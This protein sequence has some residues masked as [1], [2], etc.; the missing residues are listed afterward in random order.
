MT[1]PLITRHGEVRMSQRGIRETDLNLGLD[2]G[3]ELGTDRVMLTTKD[4][5]KLIRIWKQEIAKIERVT[6]KVF[7]VS[8]GR[9]VTAYHPARPIR[10]SH[11]VPKARRRARRQSRNR[12]RA[13]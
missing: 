3:T 1:R 10:P 11:E 4:A 12:R 5:A 9:L 13:L 7:V 8:E 2:Y 6:G